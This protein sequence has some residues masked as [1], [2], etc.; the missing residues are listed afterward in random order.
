M[1]GGTA[2]ERNW[3]CSLFKEIITCITMSNGFDHAACSFS[4]LRSPSSSATRLQQSHQLNRIPG[5][6]TP[7]TRTGA[8]LEAIR[9]WHHSSVHS[10][11][12]IQS[13]ACTSV[14]AP[15][16]AV[17]RTSPF[18]WGG[19]FVDPRCGCSP[20]GLAKVADTGERRL[21]IEEQGQRAPGGGAGRVV[22]AAAAVKVKALGRCGDQGARCRS[23]VL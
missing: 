16:R 12:H 17:P 18:G 19:G 14:I 1:R 13:L 4:M 8:H 5:V 21:E 23:E 10:S 15:P 9:R 7:P 20:P 22:E 2:V 3:C 11:P 6:P